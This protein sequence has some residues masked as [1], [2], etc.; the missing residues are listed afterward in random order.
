M[1][2][3]IIRKINCN[4]IKKNIINFTIA[5]SYMKFKRKTNEN[6]IKNNVKVQINIIMFEWVGCRDN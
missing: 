5:Y 4:Q 2:T 3:N 6:G 1:F